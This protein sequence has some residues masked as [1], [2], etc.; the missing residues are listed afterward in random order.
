MER[1]YNE[2]ISISKRKDPSLN[3]EINIKA[4]N[5]NNLEENQENVKNTNEGI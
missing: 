2:C 5:Q 1:I 4:I 3:N